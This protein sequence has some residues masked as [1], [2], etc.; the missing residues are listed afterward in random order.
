MVI[1][2]FQ[3]RSGERGALSTDL[4]VA[5]SILAVA[6]LPVAYAFTQE[7]RLC[8]NYYGE[9][10]AMEIVDGEME[11]LAAG[12]WRAFPPGAQPYSVRADAAKNLPPGRFTLTVGEQTVRLEWSPT[13]RGKGRAVMRE[14][15]IR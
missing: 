2:L 1:H 7:M 6:V 10:V 14:A 8:R 11:I 4:I 5:M 9:A 13:Q 12:E 15:K 3:H